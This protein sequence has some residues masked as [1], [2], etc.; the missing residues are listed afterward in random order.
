MNKYLFLLSFFLTSAAK[1]QYPLL[2]GTYT[3]KGNSE[4]IYIYLFDAKTGSSSLKSVAKNVVNPSYLTFSPDK[5]YLYSVNESGAG[6]GVSAF[7]YHTGKAE[8]SFLNRQEAGGNDPCFIIANAQHIF[9]ANYSGGSISIFSRA[10]DGSVGEL[11]QL[12][13]HTGRSIDPKRQ[14][15]AHVHQI[16]FSPD[17]RYLLVTDLGEDQV[18]SYRYQ[19]GN[20]ENILTPAAI[21]KTKAGSGPRHLAFSPD[22][23]FVYLT[24]ELDGR[25]MVFDYKNGVLRPVQETETA[26]QD[27]KG[28]IDGA[29]IHISADGKFLYQTNR[30]DL[31]TISVFSILRNGTLQPIE[32]ISTLG[33]GPRNFCIDPSGNFLLV[34]HQHS[35]EVVIFKRNKTTGRLSDSGERLKTGAPVCLLFAE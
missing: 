2:I 34:A 24:H 23:K 11:K 17:N 10:A 9:L 18:Y 32:T 5:K 27:F 21:F 4:G 12:I 7:R 13:R 22:G 30:G 35:D 8:L 3:N 31:N 16:Q 1:A 29:D 33:K 26:P 20:T 28:K 15:S 19:P 6:S 14:N 25:I